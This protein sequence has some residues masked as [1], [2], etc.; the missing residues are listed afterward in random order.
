ILSGT[1]R[2]VS[3]GTSNTEETTDTT[4]S[5]QLIP[6]QG[7][8]VLRIPDENTLPSILASLKENNTLLKELFKKVDRIE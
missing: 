3:A 2:C 8:S 7:K 1:A 4:A 6:P 5:R